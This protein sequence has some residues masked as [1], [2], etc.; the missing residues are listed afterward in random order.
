MTLSIPH[1]TEDSYP[2]SGMIPVQEFLPPLS[3]V[4]RPGHSVALRVSHDGGKGGDARHAVH[5]AE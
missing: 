4:T 3:C 1:R 5:T 2:G